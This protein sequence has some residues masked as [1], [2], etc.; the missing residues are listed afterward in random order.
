MRFHLD[1]PRHNDV[2]VW[3]DLD[4]VDGARLARHVVALVG[5][6]LDARPV[7]RLALNVLELLVVDA[8]EVGVVVATLD[9]SAASSISQPA[10]S[11]R[12]AAVGTRGRRARQ[13]LLPDDVPEEGR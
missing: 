10:A 8:Q 3:V 6:Y 1:G 11:V 4:A 13:G 7:C 9:R 5:R 2:R 12:L